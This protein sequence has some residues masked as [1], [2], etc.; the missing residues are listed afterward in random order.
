M[1]ISVIGTNGLLSNAIGIY[2]EKQQI[3]I[4]SYG[5]TEPVAHNYASFQ[6]LDLLKDPID[7]KNICQYQI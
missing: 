7:Y 5:L 1:N 2:C 6:S 3:K 4:N